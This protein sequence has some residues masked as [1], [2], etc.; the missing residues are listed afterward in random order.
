MADSAGLK[1]ENP[2]ARLS[3]GTSKTTHFNDN[4]KVKVLDES[5]HS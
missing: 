1:V 5:S 3:Q 2:T 4:I